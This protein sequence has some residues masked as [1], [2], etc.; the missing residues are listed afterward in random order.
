MDQPPA[1]SWVSLL[2]RSRS[3]GE[4]KITKY[5]HTCIHTY[6]HRAGGRAGDGEGAS[7]QEGSVGREGR[8]G[9]GGEGGAG[10]PQINIMETYFVINCGSIFCH[11]LWGPILD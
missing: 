11:K 3:R 10:R 2:H 1:H 8:G 5:I 9:R 7:G 6:I 4:I